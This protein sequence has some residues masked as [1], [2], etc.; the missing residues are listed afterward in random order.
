MSV[1]K[2]SFIA[3]SAYRV[4]NLVIFSAAINIAE[5]VNSNEVFI[6]FAGVSAKSRFDFAIR[7]ANTTI[8]DGALLEG[9]NGILANAISLNPGGYFCSGAFV[10]N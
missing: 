4:G 10:V 9:T 8:G 1:Q 7:D 3:N 5:T 6:Q 2:G